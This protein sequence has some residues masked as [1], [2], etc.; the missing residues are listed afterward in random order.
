M[1][2]L[3]ANFGQWKPRS[4]YSQVSVS[5]VWAPRQGGHKLGQSLTLREAEGRPGCAGHREWSLLGDTAPSLIQASG[6]GKCCLPKEGA[7]LLDLVLTACAIRAGQQSPAQPCFVNGFTW[8]SLSCLLL[9]Q[10]S[11]AAW[12]SYYSGMIRR[13]KL[14]LLAILIVPSVWCIWLKR[15]RNQRPICNQAAPVSLIMQ[16]RHTCRRTY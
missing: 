4:P 3:P 6:Y 10:P 13:K 11:K 2:S 7:Q 14:Q 1:F 5:W 12:D 15:N 8:E 16:M 9:V